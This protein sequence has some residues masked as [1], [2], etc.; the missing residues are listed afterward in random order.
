MTDA[1]LGSRAQGPAST[2]CELLVRYE[3]DPHDERRL[4]HLRTACAVVASLGAVAILLGDVP[5]PVFM[6][7]ALALLISLAWL[8]QARK[9][10]QRAAAPARYSLA[11]HRRGFWLDEGKVPL[12]VPFAEVSGIAVDEERLDIVVTRHHAEAIRLE[13]R[14]PGVAIHELMATLRNAWDQVRDR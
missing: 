9:A 3:V 1:E 2:P 11:I 8:A 7:A 10:R 12:F 5:I 4:S 6:A 13:P 14:Y